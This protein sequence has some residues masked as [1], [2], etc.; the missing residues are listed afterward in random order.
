[1]PPERVSSFV[2]LFYISSL[3]PSCLYVFNLSLEG[4]MK[5]RTQEE[6]G[7]DSNEDVRGDEKNSGE[8]TKKIISF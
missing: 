8:M 4:R 6:E 1:M 2:S 5:R 7:D 3:S